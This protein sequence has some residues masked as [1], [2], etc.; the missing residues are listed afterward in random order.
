MYAGKK[1]ERSRARRSQ[2]VAWLAS[3]HFIRMS[4]TMA[5]LVP[6]PAALSMWSRNQRGPSLEIGTTSFGLVGVGDG[7]SLAAGEAVLSRESLE[8]VG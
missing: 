1:R 2:R 8:R 3:D 5:A 4:R 6:I 7:R